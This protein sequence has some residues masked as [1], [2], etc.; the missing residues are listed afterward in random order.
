VITGLQPSSNWITN[1]SANVVFTVAAGGTAP[2]SYQWSDNNGN[3][4]AWGTNATLVL[5]N[6]QT[7]QSGSYAVS[8]TGFYG[9]PVTTN[10]N[11]TVSQVPQLLADITPA[12]V[13]VYT[14]A[15]ETLSVSV[16]GTPPLSYQWYQDGTAIP[17]A[18]NTTYAFAALLGANT[19]YVTVTNIYSAGSPLTSSTA[20]V[21]GLPIV[22]LTASNFTDSLKI[23]F[24]GYTRGETLSDFPVLV[25]LS[26]NLAGFNYSHFADPV[27]GS[28]LRFTDAGGARVIPHE[29]DQWNTN[30]ESDIWVQVPA[31]SGTNTVIW[32]YWGNPA[33]ATLPAYATNGAVWLSQALESLPPYD[34]VYH[35]QQSGPPYLDSTLQYP[36]TTTN[37][38]VLTNGMIAAG[39]YFSRDPYLDVGSVNLGNAF[40][41]SAWAKVSS[42]VSDIQC[43]WAN[44]P[45]VANSA[46]IFFYVNDY[47]TDDGALVLS[48]GNG[49]TQDQVIAPAGTV[50]LDQ[51][52][53][54]TAV[55]DRA[56]GPAQLYVDGNLVAS[57]SARNDFPT[58]VDM[59]LGR[60][61]GGSFSFLGS[62]DEARIYSG[63]ESSNWVWASWMTVAQSTNLQSYAAV[64]STVIPP[65]LPVEIIAHFSAENVTLSGSGGNPGAT[66]YVIGSTNLMLSA[67]LWP[68]IVTTNFDSYGNFSVNV[69]ISTVTPAL[70]VR[71]KE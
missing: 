23:T 54:L 32:A 55:V 30:G 46:Q 16:S 12:N 45:G 66:Y 19:Y 51:W 28:D 35:L 42:G 13:T 62:L 5:T 8:V 39:D 17:N 4:I 7:S 70:Y 61:T 31:V 22:T 41:L 33:A 11:L 57:G 36:A 49:T 64:V 15:P 67:A 10:V 59:E 24:A 53:L 26:T 63:L 69:P 52:H 6:V 50:S 2:F 1:Q 27:G 18:T 34:A 43:V 29:I 44:G 71:I 56:D 65:A 14:S 40:T 68:V 3:L 47:K 9:G 60:D 58:N 25:R 20:T 38:P 21:T 37:A 48:T